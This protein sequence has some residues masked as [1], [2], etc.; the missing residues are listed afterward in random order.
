[1]FGPEFSPD[2]STEIRRRLRAQRWGLGGSFCL[3]LRSA[4]Q[5]RSDNGIWEILVSMDRD[6]RSRTA[7]CVE[8]HRIHVFRLPLR[9]IQC[10]ES[11]QT[12]CAQLKAP[13]QSEKCRSE[14]I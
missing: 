8:E 4:S 10:I 1:M 6:E 7:S 5:P 9:S 12:S 14:H 3:A 11:S 13:A 2:R